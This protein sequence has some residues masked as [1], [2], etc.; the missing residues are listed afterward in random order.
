VNLDL[1]TRNCRLGCELLHPQSLPYIGGGIVAQ[2]AAWR[3]AG[4]ASSKIEGQSEFQ[5]SLV[6]FL[7]GFGTTPLF[8]LSCA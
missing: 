2:P 5:Q 4:R 3:A 7:A 8:C 1:E 6:S